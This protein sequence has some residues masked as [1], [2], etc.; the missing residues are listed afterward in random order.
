MID[1]CA[2]ENRSAPF[3]EKN[4]VEFTINVLALPISLRNAA[5]GE[6]GVEASVVTSQC[7][8]VQSFDMRS[9]T[10]SSSPAS[11]SLPTNSATVL[12]VCSGSATK[13]S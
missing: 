7:R 3:T 2:S 11:S 4:L 12:T 13:S 5:G 10:I 6:N 1:S 8:I 9:V